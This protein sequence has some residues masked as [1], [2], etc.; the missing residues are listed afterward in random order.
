M[1]SYIRCVSSAHP[2][3]WAQPEHENGPLWCLGQPP[4]PGIVHL[5][6][7]HSYSTMTGIKT[8]HKT[9]VV[10]NNA[11]DQMCHL[12][13]FTYSLNTH[14]HAATGIHVRC[15]N[16]LLLLAGPALLRIAC[17]LHNRTALP[18]LERVMLE[19]LEGLQRQVAH[20]ESSELVHKVVERH[21]AS[22]FVPT[23]IHTRT[24]YIF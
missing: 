11:I 19:F 24:Q 16:R 3:A 5:Y 8:R 21:P 12:L 22:N 15:P 9:D 10:P 1:E 20:L 17:E 13:K 18:F 14:I 7:R 23:I 4:R 6:W 2:F